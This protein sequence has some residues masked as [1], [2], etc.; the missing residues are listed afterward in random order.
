MTQ[1]APYAIVAARA[2]PEERGQLLGV[3]NV[4]IVLPQMA[5]L[6]LI[7]LAGAPVRALLVGGAGCAFAAAALGLAMPVPGGH[8]L[9]PGRAA[10]GAPREDVVEHAATR[11]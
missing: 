11:A 8:T 1:S 4:F 2:G 10:R 6:L 3:L 7:R 5:D 9:A